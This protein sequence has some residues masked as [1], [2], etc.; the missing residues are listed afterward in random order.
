[1]ID[2]RL[3]ILQMVRDGKITIDDAEALLDA[4]DA[5]DTLRHDAPEK[6]KPKP[7]PKREAAPDMAR[8]R[9]YWDYPFIVG[10]LILGLAGLCAT[11]TSVLLL[12][13]CGWSVFALGGLIALGGWLSQWSP[14]AHV[15]IRERDGDRIAFSVPLP[16][17]LVGSLVKGARRVAFRFVDDDTA[18]NLDTAASFLMMAEGLSFD[19]PLEVEVDEEDGD[20]IQVFIG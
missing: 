1:M 6:R 14:W 10:L 19:Q 11:N 2:E 17:R 9:R 3:R 20:H 8:F 16:L 7:K 5:K 4:L 13:L 18:E 15:R 12:D